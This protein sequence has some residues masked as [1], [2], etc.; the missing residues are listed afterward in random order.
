MDN[1]KEFD[2]RVKGH[3]PVFFQLY[4]ALE[5]LFEKYSTEWLDTKTIEEIE[6]ELKATEHA[7]ITRKRFKSQARYDH[8]IFLCACVMKTLALFGPGKVEKA[9]AA[10]VRVARGEFDYLEEKE[11]E[12]NG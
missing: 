9:W 12:V 3:R 6:T 8:M 10:L 2:R 4:N 1:L 11:G 7:P 5:P